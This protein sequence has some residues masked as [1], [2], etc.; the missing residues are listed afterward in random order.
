MLHHDENHK[1][2]NIEMCYWPVAITGYGCSVNTAAG[3]DLAA[4]IGDLEPN[5]KKYFLKPLDM[6]TV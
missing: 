5:F 6:M 1:T 3:D 2:I 4:K